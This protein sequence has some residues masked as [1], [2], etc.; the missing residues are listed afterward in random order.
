MRGRSRRACDPGGCK[1]SE[2]QVKGQKQVWQ[3]GGGKGC[4]ISSI[5][6]LG[7]VSCHWCDWRPPNSSNRL[8]LRI[9]NE[10]RR[11]CTECTR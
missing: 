10:T 6:L 7:R 4:N 1:V 5:G 9:R 11:D 8:A 3:S 2:D